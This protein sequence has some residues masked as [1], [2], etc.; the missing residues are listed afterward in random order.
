MKTFPP[1]VA[2]KLFF[3][4]LVEGRQAILRAKEERKLEVCDE[5]AEYTRLLKQVLKNAHEAHRR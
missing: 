3:D 5:E 4:A 2:Q 1:F